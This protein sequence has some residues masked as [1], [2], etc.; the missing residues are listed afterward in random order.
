ML[1]SGEYM[2][3]VMPMGHPEELSGRGD[4]QGTPG[5]QERGMCL[6]EVWDPLAMWCHPV[7]E[8]VGHK[9]HGSPADGEGHTR[10]VGGKPGDWDTRSPEKRVSRMRVR[11]AGLKS[12]GR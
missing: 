4:M 2:L 11:L 9:E 3:R 5:P 1:D 7:A 10:K 6:T 12:G 8:G